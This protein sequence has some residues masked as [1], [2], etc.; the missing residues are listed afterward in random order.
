MADTAFLDWPFF[1]DEQRHLAAQLYDWLDANAG[2]LAQHPV[3]DEA[4]DAHCRRLVRRLG[5]GGLLSYCVPKQYGGG[6]DFAVRNL[7][8]CRETLAR[9]SGLADFAF[10]MQGLGSG[11]ISF[12]GSE[13]LKRRYLPDVAAGKS[14]AAFAISEVEAGSDVAAMQ[15]TATHD[16]DSYVLDGAKTWISNAGIADHYV[17][18]ART[19]DAPGAKGLSAFVVDAQ[20]PGLA[21]SER[22]EVSAPHP[23][24]SLEFDGCRVPAENMVAGPGDGIRVALGTLD[25]FR[26]TVG[27][28]AV[29]FARRAFDEAVSRSRERRAFGSFLSD[30][31]LTKAKIADMAV[32][33]DAAKLLV[34]RAAWA[35]DTSSADGISRY[36]SMAKLFATE[37]AQ[38]VI[39]QAV[40]IFGG[41]GVVRGMVVERLYREI[42]AL[43]I[44]EGT[45]EIQK[46]VIAG[47]VLKE[48]GDGGE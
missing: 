21:V 22:I 13:A 29:G 8:L 2:L 32:G 28:A 45:S 9:D 10:A 18:F 4:I 24:G 20:T 15:T 17:V 23:L 43:R 48:S 25:V 34:Y 7:C 35:K 33:I 41:L 44:Y 42:R 40:Q 1:G 27:A 5:E 14:I 39:D 46:L 11:P 47:E 3:G 12:F 37:E 38:K 31:Q 16:G 30:F 36:A 19:G 6:A 26:A